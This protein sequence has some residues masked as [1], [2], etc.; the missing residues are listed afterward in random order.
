MS[1]LKYFVSSKFFLPIILILITI[2]TYINILPNQLFYD[3]E[4]LIYKNTYV[5]NLRLFPKF[6]TEN[7][8][9]GAGK[10]S[11]MY[12]PILLTSLAIDYSIWKTNPT[13][14]HLTSLLLHTCNALLVF[15]LINLL[16]ENRLLAFL[17]GIIFSVHPVQSEAVAYA[18]GRTDL[19]FSI[20]S[21]ISIIFLIYFFKRKTSSLGYYLFSLTAYIFALLSKETAVITPLLL[22]M[23]L[24]LFGRKFAANSFRIISLLFP[25]LTVTVLYILS[26]LTIFNFA[27]SVNFYST[28]NLYSQN[29]LIRIYT[30]TKVFFDYVLIIFFPKDLIYSRSPVII[31]S[32]F[33]IWV[34]LF[35]AIII[36]AGTIVY[37]NRNKNPIYIFIFLWFFISIFPVSGII[38]I[39]SIISEHYLYLPSLSFFLL[40]SYIFNI[41]YNKILHRRIRLALTS[42]LYFI[43][44]VLSTRTII[45]NS[46]WRNPIIFYT[47]S[48]NYSPW[49]IPMRH[50]L[51]M[52]Y[53]GK[54]QLDLAISEYKYL[55]NTADV[56][57]NTHH[58]LANAYKEKGLY[59]EAE[60]EYQIALKM[61]PNFSFSYAGLIDLYQ[62]TGEKEKM[63]E[64][65]K[66]VNKIQVNN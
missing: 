43:V 49:N 40:F 39:N 33:N 50:N 52:T 3:D 17:T 54:G 47:R 11:N 26:R 19:L 1:Q 25:F 8:T 53:A 14:Y 20:F 9:A 5:Q 38:P 55:I 24:F 64:I 66:K 61:D 2:V 58:N 30:F 28:P 44:C 15:F 29:I 31:T 10:L 12:R 16:F 21:L 18:S 63:E 22:L 34:F 37:I 56:Y 35:L 23:I 46:D 51:A 4:E 7:M 62:K 36:P 59:K 57:P 32:F 60:M 13:G 42:S 48:L 65:L 6:F 41:I 45:R 27:N